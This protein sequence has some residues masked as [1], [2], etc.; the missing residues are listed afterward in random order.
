VTIVA[1]FKSREGIVLCADTQETVGESKRNIPKLRFEPQDA[2]HL[3]STERRSGGV[4]L[5]AADNG[6]FM[7]EMV[8]R[9]WEDVQTATSLD[10]ACDSIR[11][12][13]K[14]HYREAKSIYQTGYCPQTELIYGVK[15]FG[16]SRLFYGLGPSI[17]ERDKYAAGGQ[18]VYLADFI[19]S[20][21]YSEHLTLRQCVILGAYILYEAKENVVGCGGNSHIAILREGGASGLINWHD[22]KAINEFLQQADNYGGELLL[23]AANFKLTE[24]QFEEEVKSVV[25]MLNALRHARIT[26]IGEHQNMLKSMLGIQEDRDDEFGFF[27][28]SDSQTSEPEQ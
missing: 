15:M 28:P 3:R 2:M 9:A 23:H 17:A 22:I 25:D 5:W 24:N 21:T 18:G 16:T 26:E 19:A 13:I 6:V 11:G 27:K 12:S 7:D 1:G 14:Q 10:E 20:R 8:D 4:F